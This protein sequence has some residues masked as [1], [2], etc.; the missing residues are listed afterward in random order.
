MAVDWMSAVKR[1][2]DLTE[3]MIARDVAWTT[4][5]RATAELEGEVPSVPSLTAQE[6]DL[7]T[8]VRTLAYSIVNGE[9]PPDPRVIEEIKGH[10]KV[11]GRIRQNKGRVNE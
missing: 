4:A 6:K 2:S 8:R 1:G 10:L 11:V 7:L 3:D 9:G 5:V